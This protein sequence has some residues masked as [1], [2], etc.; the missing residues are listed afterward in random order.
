[1]TYDPQLPTAPAAPAAAVAVAGKPRAKSGGILNLLL[2]GAAIIAIGGVA[3]A[4]GRSTAPVST[5]QGLGA[6]GGGFQRPGA[7]GAPGGGGGGGGAGGG[8]LG[9]AISV[10]GTVT[11]V[12]GGSLTLTLDNGNDVTFT[13][14]GATAYHESTDAAADA[15]AVGDQVSV[16]VVG[17][18][19][20]LGADGQATVPTASDVTVAR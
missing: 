2:I 12:D 9:G 19:R 11:A 18:G 15:V 3:F 8:G 13:L 10:A 7:S 17:G 1:M 4:V 14:D 5:V 6:N 16:G 20:G